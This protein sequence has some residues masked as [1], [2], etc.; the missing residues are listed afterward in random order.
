MIGVW[1]PHGHLAPGIHKSCSKN[2]EICVFAEPIHEPLCYRIC[3]SS[4]PSHY[5]RRSQR[6][7]QSL[8]DGDY[9]CFELGVCTQFADDVLGMFPDCV[10]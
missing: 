6:E 3:S 1:K 4:T 8:S 5:G 2:R 10:E 7:N 9:D